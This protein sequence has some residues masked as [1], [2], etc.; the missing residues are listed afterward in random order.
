MRD[1]MVRETSVRLGSNL[2]RPHP[3]GNGTT[4]QSKDVLPYINRTQVA[5]IDLDL[6][7]HAARDQTR[8]PCEFGAIP[9]SGSRAMSYTAVYSKMLTEVLPCPI[10]SSS[11][12]PRDCVGL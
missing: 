2:R 4:N 9:F 7:T 5:E 10:S 1:Q 11:V 6:Q 8:L 3:A 12:E